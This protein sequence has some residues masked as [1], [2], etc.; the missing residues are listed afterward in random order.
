MGDLTLHL[1]S[2][3]LVKIELKSKKNFK[4]LRSFTEKKDPYFLTNQIV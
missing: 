3:P 4:F 1:H 2:F